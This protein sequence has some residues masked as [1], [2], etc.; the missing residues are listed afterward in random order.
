MVT[1]NRK[2]MLPHLENHLAQGRHIPGI[3]VMNDK[4]GIGE[5]IEELLLIWGASD[6]KEYRDRISYLPVSS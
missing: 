2:S 4:M 6:E 1:N 5:T 3:I